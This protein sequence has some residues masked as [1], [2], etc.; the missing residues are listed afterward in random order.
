MRVFLTVLLLLMLN[1]A[2]ASE[3]FS[4][5]CEGGKP[6]MPYFATFDTDAKT[7]VLKSP[8]ANLSTY[9]GVD[10]FAGEISSSGD[11]PN[12]RIEYTIRVFD[13]K[14]SLTFDVSRR[15]MIWPGLGDLT[16]RPTLSHSCTVID[17]RSILSFRT[18][19][20][21]LHPIS[22]RC[23]EAGYMYFTMDPEAKRAIFERDHG[24]MFGGEVTAVH[25]DDIVL[26]MKFDTPTRVLWSKNRQTITA[27]SIDGNSPRFSRTMQCEETAPRTMI[28]YHK[29]LK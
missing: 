15:K 8:P 13:G 23:S 10:V 18:P 20:P 21:I 2:S 25:G 4:V 6:A 22:I 5:R 19:D 24:R 3:L 1:G 14:L 26:L 7:V 27:E 11:R 29:R 12:G 17:P 16:F 9:E 28:E